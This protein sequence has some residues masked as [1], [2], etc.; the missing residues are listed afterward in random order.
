MKRRK[1]PIRGARGRKPKPFVR[2]ETDLTV[3]RLIHAVVMYKLHE[4]YD[5]LT[6]ARLARELFPKDRKPK[7]SVILP[8]VRAW[9]EYEGTCIDCG[10]REN[11]R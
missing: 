9:D 11:G 2:E 8:I 5:H 3:A 7:L 6:V 10:E 1:A 4:G